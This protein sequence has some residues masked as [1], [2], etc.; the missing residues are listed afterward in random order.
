MQNLSADEQA[1]IAAM[2]DRADGSQVICIIRSS[3]GA[4]S[5]IVVLDHVSEGFVERLAAESTSPTVQSP[6]RR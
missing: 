4:K 6:T 5:E 2:R 1:A 3:G